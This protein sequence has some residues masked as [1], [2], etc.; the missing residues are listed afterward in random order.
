LNRRA[1]ADPEVRDFFATVLAWSRKSEVTRRYEIG[2]TRLIDTAGLSREALYPLALAGRRAELARGL[3]PTLHFWR[4]LLDQGFPFIKAEVLRD[5][6]RLR[7]Q[8][9]STAGDAPPVLDSD[10]T[11][12]LL[13]A[14]GFDIEAVRAHMER[15]RGERARNAFLGAAAGS[16]GPDTK[17]FRRRV[18]R[19]LGI[20]TK[21]ERITAR[22]KRD[23]DRSG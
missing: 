9:G 12:A 21:K 11:S 15:M 22:L 10:A 8:L 20:P 14:H 13:A 3:N 18:M 5:A 4:H 17:A 23:H 6:D 1:L 2:L 7:S 19:L 16:V